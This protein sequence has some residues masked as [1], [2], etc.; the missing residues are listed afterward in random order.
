M[1]FGALVV[2]LLIG[3]GGV[4]VAFVGMA[5]FSPLAVLAAG[6]RIRRIDEEASIPVVEMGVLRNMEIFS[7]LPAASLETLAREAS[8]DDGRPRH[9]RSSARATSGTAT[10]RSL[11][12]RS[13]SP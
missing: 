6:R 8:Y 2:P 12:A 3:L 11:T 13:S 9:G 7:A 1:A 4:K 10:T 5:C